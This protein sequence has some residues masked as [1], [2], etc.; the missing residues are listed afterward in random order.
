M[1]YFEWFGAVVVLCCKLEQNE[2][3]INVVW[4]VSNLGLGAN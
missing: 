4:V 3:M 2:N 1:N